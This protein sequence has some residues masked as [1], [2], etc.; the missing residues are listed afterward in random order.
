MPP[1]EAPMATTVVLLSRTG[2]AICAFAALCRLLLPRDFCFMNFPGF[3]LE[4][5]FSHLAY[6]VLSSLHA[7]VNAACY[8]FDCPRFPGWKRHYPR[9]DLP[10]SGGVFMLTVHSTQHT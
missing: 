7:Q 1:A 10:L 9:T 3:L 2:G 5:D 6:I 4:R 8:G